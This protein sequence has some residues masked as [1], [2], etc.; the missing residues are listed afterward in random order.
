M[1]PRSLRG[2]CGVPALVRADALGGLDFSHPFPGVGTARG[3]ELLHSVRLRQ[4][5]GVMA[6]PGL[7]IWSGP[8]SSAG[9]LSFGL[10]QAGVSWAARAAI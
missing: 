7:S 8:L 4:K 6:G 2:Q 3:R 1:S 5:E 10:M 9:L